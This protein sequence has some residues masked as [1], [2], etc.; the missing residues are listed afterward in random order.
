MTSQSYGKY[1]NEAICSIGADADPRHISLDTLA[2]PGTKATRGKIHPPNCDC[3]GDD[4][5][6]NRSTSADDRKTLRKR[7]RRKYL[8]DGY[9][10]ALVD[11]AKLNEESSL[12][13]SYWNTYHC[14]RTLTLQSD[15]NITGA[16]CKNRWCLV[17][18]AIRTA[19]LIKRYGETLDGWPDKYFVTLTIP[20]V[21]AE[22]LPHALDLMSDL[23]LKCKETL[24]KRGQRGQ[25]PAFEGLRKLEVT[26][27]PE[28]NDFHP[29]YHVIVSTKEAARQLYN[30]WLKGWTKKRWNKGGAI[31]GRSY[32]DI[33]GE[34]SPKA[35]DLKPATQ[36]AT[37]ELFKYFTKVIQGSGKAGRVVYADALDKIFNAVKGKRVFQPFGFT[38]PEVELTAEEKQAAVE[39]AEPYALAEYTWDKEK[40]DW[41]IDGLAVD[42]ETG[43]VIE[44][45]EQLTGYTPGDALKDLIETKILIRPGHTWKRYDKAEIFARR[46]GIPL[47]EEELKRDRQYI[48]RGH[49]LMIERHRKQAARE[50]SRVMRQTELEL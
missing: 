38:T 29:H 30:L 23:F 45:A 26:Y 48:A 27:N 25:C 47:D 34:L 22:N 16:Y 41:A 17:C 42:P 31:Y 20:N 14:A 43:E 44:A 11:A 24:K 36:N 50:L 19:Q 7:A 6:L 40:T 39:G 46:G 9:I 10:G 3:C 13:K 35:Q 5:T 15:G 49:R 1:R 4:I 2:Q 8:T 21:E 28:R 12:T 18:N 37:L 33:Y 32:A